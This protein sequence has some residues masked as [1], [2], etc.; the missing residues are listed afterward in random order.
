MANYESTVL[1]YI[2]DAASNDVE[3]VIKVII[4]PAK[5]PRSHATFNKCIRYIFFYMDN[6]TTI[7]YDWLNDLSWGF[8][9]NMSNNPFDCNYRFILIRLTYNALFGGA[10]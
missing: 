8:V 7:R 6:R 3:D 9:Q 5:P 4:Y 10:H 1:R 2:S